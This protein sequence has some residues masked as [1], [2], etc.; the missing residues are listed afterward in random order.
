MNHTGDEAMDIT[1]VIKTKRD[2]G[3]LSKEEIYWFVDASTKHEIA[4]YQISAMLMAMFIRGLDEEETT[5]LTLAMRDSG[6][7]PDLSVIPGVKV[8]KI[9]SF[10]DFYF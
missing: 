4:D 5:W 9:K 3:K 1:N 2:G 8:D 6:E 10:K 7:K